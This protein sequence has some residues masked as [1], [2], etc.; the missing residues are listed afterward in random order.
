MNEF[1]NINFNDSYDVIAVSFISLIKDMSASE[2]RKNIEHR[3]ISLGYDLT[4]QLT[5]TVHVNGIQ[6]QVEK[7]RKDIGY[8]YNDKPCNKIFPTLVE[9]IGSNFCSG[10]RIY[11]ERKRS[12][13]KNTK[14]NYDEMKKGLETG[15]KEINNIPTNS[16]QIS[17][18]KI[19][20]WSF[21]FSSSF[22]P[23]PKPKFKN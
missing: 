2:L 1:K 17:A 6:N 10:L 16:N 14:E 18:D 20:K 9:D 21:G 3:L 4:S 13:K 23:S 8:K 15:L 5:T 22:N 7:Y 19:T 12:G 11:N